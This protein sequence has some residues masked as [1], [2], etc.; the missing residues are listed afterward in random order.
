M[1]D[2]TD[3]D[4]F[5]VMKSW[6]YELKTYGPKDL[7]L[8]IVGNKSDL[9]DQEKVSYEEAKSFARDNSAVFK[10]VSTKESIGINVK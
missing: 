4:S 10:I 8:A 3:K 7:L 6:V 2:I 9:I 5:D 1:Y